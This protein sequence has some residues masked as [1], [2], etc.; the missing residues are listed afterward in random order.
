MDNPQGNP[1]PAALAAW[2]SLRRPD[3]PG[4]SCSLGGVLVLVP[5]PSPY[6]PDD[7]KLRAG[8][9]HDPPSLQQQDVDSGSSIKLYSKEYSGHDYGY[10][11]ANYKGG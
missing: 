6:Q 9:M 5:S 2:S 3:S 8:K 10:T 4:A 11:K 7:L 1:P